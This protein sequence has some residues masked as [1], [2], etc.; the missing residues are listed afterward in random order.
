MLVYWH[1]RGQNLC[2]DARSVDVEDATRWVKSTKSQEIEIDV[3]RQWDGPSVPGCATRDASSHHASVY[4]VYTKTALKS[5][6]IEKERCR[7]SVGATRQVNVRS[8]GSGVARPA[9]VSR[10][11]KR[12]AGGGRRGFC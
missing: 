7:M 10:G 9:V 4:I 3:K 1:R 12:E 5:N 8:K 2:I 6:R 11:E